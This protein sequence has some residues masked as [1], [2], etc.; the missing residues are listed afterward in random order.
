MAK[1]EQ[2]MSASEEGV[3]YFFSTAIL[4]LF[5]SSSREL[6]RGGEVDLQGKTEAMKR[7]RGS[8]KEARCLHCHQL[9]INHH[10]CSHEAARKHNLSALIRLGVKAEC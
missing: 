7:F 6:D 5:A 2:R 4:K 1:V 10:R 9:K 3:Y 8:E